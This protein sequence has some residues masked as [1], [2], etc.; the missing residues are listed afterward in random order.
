M[1]AVVLQE[2]Q[3]S[4]CNI[5]TASAR[6]SQVRF[7]CHQVHFAQARLREMTLKDA[8]E[9]KPKPTDSASV[10]LTAARFA[11]SARS[12]RSARCLPGVFLVKVVLLCYS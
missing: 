9:V 6:G 4:Y 5:R 12:A 2:V 1:F 11:K 8:K 3:M 7:V 10:T